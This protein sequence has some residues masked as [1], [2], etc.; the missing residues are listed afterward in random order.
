[1]QEVYQQAVEVV[2][3]VEAELLEG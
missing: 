1:M 2:G 3:G